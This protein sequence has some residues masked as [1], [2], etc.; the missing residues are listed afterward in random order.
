V[1]ESE[2]VCQASAIIAIEK[3]FTPTQYFKPK[4]RVFRM[5]EITPSKYPKNILYSFDIGALKLDFE[6]NFF[7]PC[8][9]S[10]H[11]NKNIIFIFSSH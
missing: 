9:P 6:N 10:P 2:K 11:N 4:R 7:T 8:H 5:I 3:V 1:S